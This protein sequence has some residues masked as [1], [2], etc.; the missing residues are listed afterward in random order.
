MRA[1]KFARAGEN[2]EAEKLLGKLAKIA[3]D[4]ADIFG[5]RGTLKV[6][7]GKYLQA[8]P[9]LK[10]ALCLDEVNPSTHASLAVAYEG[11]AKPDKAKRHYLRALELDPGSA[12]THLNFGA[13]LWQ[14]EEHNSAIEHYER[15]IE[16]DPEFSEAYGSLAWAM[17]FAGRIDEALRCG[18]TAVRLEPSSAR[19]HMNLGQF[20]QANGSIKD[21]IRH[22]LKAIDLDAR[23]AEVYKCYAYARHASV[24]DSFSDDLSSALALRDWDDGER[25]FLHYAAGKWESDLGRDKA[26]FTHW[27]KGARLRRKSFDY[28]TAKSRT[29]L[30][31]YRTVFDVP[32]LKRRL[33]MPVEGPIPIFIVGMP[34][35]G[36]TLVEQI[37]ASHPQVAGLGELP[38]IAEVAN[39][40]SKWSG[41]AGKYPAALTELGGFHWAGAANL[42]M[43]RLNWTGSESYISDKMPSIFLYMGFISLLFPNARIVHCRRNALDT[44]LSCFTNYF[45]EGQQWS[46]DLREIGQYYGLYLD[47]MAHWRRV[48]PL[49]IHEIQYESVVS[50]LEGEARKLLKFC[51]LEWHP[52]CLNFHQSKRPVF[53]ASSAQVRQPLYSSSVGRWRR[54]EQQL[55]PLIDNL[56]PG[57]I[58]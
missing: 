21:A 36:T 46:Y 53:T 58:A 26:A 15:A 13:L 56:P 31:S 51:G 42:Y 1:S 3:P 37:L 14:V 5:L 54:Y 49:P 44:C 24:E 38:H 17:H 20:L 2:R 10:R 7:L 43:E 28:T 11:L 23:L 40:V 18:E 12:R 25:A 8:V 6:Q 35:S 57:A 22:Y 39:G 55:Q 9:L 30:E 34:R 48:L 4:N 41:V 19:G 29:I 32:L 27:L 50:D 16:L 47:L 33:N 52:D 45:A